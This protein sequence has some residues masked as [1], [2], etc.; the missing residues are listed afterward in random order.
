MVVMSRPG[1]ARAGRLVGLVVM[2]RRGGARAERSADSTRSA[3]PG[4]RQQLQFEAAREAASTHRRNSVQW[5]SMLRRSRSRSHLRMTAVGPN[6]QQLI[7]SLRQRSRTS[8]IEGKPDGRRT[9][10]EPALLTHTRPRT[11]IADPTTARSV[12]C[13]RSASSPSPRCEFCLTAELCG[14]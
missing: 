7:W 6:R 3:P 14:S 8:A 4:W 5:P 10:P 12:T 9:R 11:E 13:P 2:S 1:G